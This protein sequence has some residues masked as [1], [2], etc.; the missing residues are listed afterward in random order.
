MGAERFGFEPAELE[1]F[2]EQYMALEGRVNEP[3]GIYSILPGA[4]E[5]KYQSTLAYFLDPQQPHGFGSEL[6]ESF[7]DTVGVTAFNLASQHV[8]I[9]EE[10]RVAD[11][12]SERRIDLVICGGRALEAHPR[13]GLF[14][15]LK[16]GAEEGADQTT[17]YATTEAWNFDWF[18]ADELVV[19]DLEETRYVYLK[20]AAAADPVA[21]TFEPVAWTAVVEGFERALRDSVFD[22][23]TRSVVQLTDF[24]Q[25]LKMTENIDDSFAADEL[26]E[27]LALYYEHREL[28][29]QV[30]Q[31][32]SQFQT[33]FEDLGEHLRTTWAGELAG[34]YD[35]EGSGWSARTSSQARFQKILPEYW[36]QDPL[37]G[38]STVIMYFRHSPTT[39]ALRSR[40][41]SFRLRLASHRSVM[42]NAY[43]DGQSFNDAFTAKCTGEY[44]DRIEDSLAGVEGVRTRLGS[45]GALLET[46]YEL[47]AGNVVGSYYEQLDA[48]VGEFCH[49][50]AAVLGVMNDVFEDA[51]TT[52]FQQEPAGEFLGVL[53]R[54]VA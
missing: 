16:V 48:A 12:D 2:I 10:V 1:D 34:R 33:D 42:T 15:E 14:L 32:N 41:L 31:A 5:G 22:Y 53:A 39:E 54:N 52:V 35:F 13:W 7:L 43:H 24:I 38:G 8:T 36:H 26:R 21:E 46:E 30:E 27:R 29:E 9:E 20:R 28:I 4:R 19:E 6:L 40:T 23:P 11:E 3:R 17:A 47:D 44:R 50:N 49:G 18:E 45:A 37:D 51:Y 25:S